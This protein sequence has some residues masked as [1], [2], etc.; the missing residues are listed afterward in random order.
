MILLYNPRSSAIKPRLVK[1]SLGMYAN[2]YQSLLCVLV[3]TYLLSY[4]FTLIYITQY[5]VGPLLIFIHL[6][7]FVRGSS[8]D[9]ST[10]YKK[11]KPINPTLFPGS[12]VCYPKTGVACTY[13]DTF[14]L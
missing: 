11:Y 4:N 13:A 9:K 7:C 2:Q 14:Q 12:S 5:K 8:C 1:L 10:I 3:K 6:F